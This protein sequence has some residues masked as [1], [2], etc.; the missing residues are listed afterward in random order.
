MDNSTSVPLR[1]PNHTLIRVEAT[2]LRRPGDTDV[3]FRAVEE[4]LEIDGIQ[5]A[6]EGI[7][8]MV[9]D[10]LS[11]LAPS[12][13]SAE[14]AIEVGLETGKLTALWVKG[15]GK[16]NLKITLEWAND[17]RSKDGGRVS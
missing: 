2:A 16:A 1:L 12:K 11:K 14:F 15:S 4:A 8:Q 3:A 17:S 5:G 7:G 13:A 10:A 6:I 9:V